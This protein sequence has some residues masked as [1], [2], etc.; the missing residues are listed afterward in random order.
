[1]TAF[2]LTNCFMVFRNVI[3]SNVS[4]IDIS[5]SK[6]F[7]K[8]KNLNFW[9]RKKKPNKTYIPAKRINF[10]PKRFPINTQIC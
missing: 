3:S 7:E 10:T 8:A 1:M 2:V 9:P 6:Q 4:L 5:S